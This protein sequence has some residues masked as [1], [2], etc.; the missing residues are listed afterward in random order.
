MISENSDA[1]AR[2]PLLSTNATFLSAPDTAMSDRALFLAAEVGNVGEAVGTAAI[3]RPGL[4]VA[5]AHI[6]DQLTRRFGAATPPP[7]ASVPYEMTASQHRSDG[8]ASVYEVGEISLI[9]GIDIAVLALTR[10][11]VGTNPTWPAPPYTVHIPAIGE[12]VLSF[13]YV[14]GEYTIEDKGATVSIW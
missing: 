13:G 12:E 10:K 6:V 7:G 1:P 2:Q 14:D 9:R 11:L 4:A 3:L 8:S 5:A